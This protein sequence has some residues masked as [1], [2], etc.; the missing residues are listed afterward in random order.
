[1]DQVGPEATLLSP[2][3]PPA[4]GPSSWQADAADATRA[5]GGDFRAFERRYRAHV[6]RI[7]ALGRRMLS[8]D[9]ASEATQDVFVR[10]WQ[11]IGSY[12]GEAAFG[13][14]LHRLAVNVMLG[15]R[16]VLKL[17]RERHLEDDS[18]L[19]LL[20]ARAQRADL[21][22]DFEA[23]L[24]LLPPGARQ[25]FVLHDV[26]GYRHEEIAQ[27]LGVTTGTTKAQLH[28]AR[29]LLRGHLDR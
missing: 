13:T 15:R 23:A 9:E 21:A 12:R 6:N 18:A 19:E 3:P 25:V 26:E 7:H 14:W 20:P 24:A 29:M 16:Q 5:A 27:L 17:E 4:A 8:P 1:M 10:A 11:K 28:R 22:V 2:P